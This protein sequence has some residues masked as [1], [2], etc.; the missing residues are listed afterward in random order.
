MKKVQVTKAAEA[1]GCKTTETERDGKTFFFDIEAPKGKAIKEGKVLSPKIEVKW[2]ATVSREAAFAAA[3][4]WL[5]KCEVVSLQEAEVKV[6]K[7]VE[8]PAAEIK[9][10]PTLKEQFTGAGEKLEWKVTGERPAAGDIV[11]QAFNAEGKGRVVALVPFTTV[12]PKK[13]FGTTDAG[14]A[15]LV[16]KAPEMFFALESIVELLAK[17]ESALAKQLIAIAQAPIKSLVK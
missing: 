15:A 9:Q 10:H 2:G 6:V 8:T 5:E 1:L 17:N 13:I 14:D 11:I 4:K 12:R 16:A 3:I 7:A